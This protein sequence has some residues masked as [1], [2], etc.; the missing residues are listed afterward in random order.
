MNRSLVVTAFA[1]GLLL[2]ACGGRTWA[3]DSYSTYN[4]PIENGYASVPQ[5]D[6]ANGVLNNADIEFNVTFSD[7]ATV[8]T[9]SAPSAGVVAASGQS[10]V[11][12]DGE[13]MLGE[14]NNGIGV[15]FN[16][17]IF[18]LVGSGYQFENVS[19]QGTG[20]SYAQVGSGAQGFTDYLGTGA[21]DFGFS[22]QFVQAQTY[23]SSGGYAWA[24]SG[25]SA[26]SGTVT[27]TYDYT[28]VPEPASLSLLALGL[29][30]CCRRRSR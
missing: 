13:M 2:A 18:N 15:N 12:Q 21:V 22:S 24:G 6:T 1:I 25:P 23:V 14:L 28:P 8:A 30:A 7:T 3:Q 5:F 19:L 10:L 17:Q 27:V 4:V 16:E 29:A 11:Y 20:T 9:D 26:V